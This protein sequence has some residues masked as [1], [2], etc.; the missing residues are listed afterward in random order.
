[1]AKLNGSIFSRSSEEKR[2]EMN[3]KSTEGFG[4]SESVL[5]NLA[6]VD[7]T[8]FICHKPER[9]GQHRKRFRRHTKAFDY[10]S[11]PSIGSLFVTKFPCHYKEFIGKCLQ[12][13]RGLQK[14]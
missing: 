8:S 12:Q 3:R 13:E 1:M 14:N 9:A 4:S 2:E 6:W 11:E 7:I 5:H 10:E